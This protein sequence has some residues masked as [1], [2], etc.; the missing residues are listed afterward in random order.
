[1][2]PYSS[3]THTTR[4]SL[5]A[6]YSNEELATQITF[7]DT[8]GLVTANEAIKYK[9]EDSLVGD[10]ERSCTEADLLLVVQDVSN[11]FVREALDKRV[12]RMLVKFH[13]IP[14]ILV[15]NK[16]GIFEAAKSSIPISNH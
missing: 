6:I 13:Q 3:K 12:L 7:V 11:R 16:L 2:C 5:Q 8:P 14:S 10:P 4:H 9:L 15:L 1:M